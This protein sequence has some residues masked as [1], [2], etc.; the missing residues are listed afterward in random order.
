[1]IYLPGNRNRGNI[2]L[3][4]MPSK[5]ESWEKE[6]ERERATVGWDATGSIEAEVRSG[7]KEV[8]EEEGGPKLAGVGE[9]EEE[10]EREG[11]GKGER[12]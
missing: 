10:M 4:L 7:R 12:E 8:R 6:G 1:M 9:T 2:T 3:V 11:D 5:R